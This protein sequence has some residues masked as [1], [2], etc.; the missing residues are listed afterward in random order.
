[1]KKILITIFLCSSVAL[2]GQRDTLSYTKAQVDSAIRATFVQI[3]GL[4]DVENAPNGN[5]YLTG[6]KTSTGELAKI[7]LKNLPIQDL[8]QAAL[9]QRVLLTAPNGVYPSYQSFYLAFLDSIRALWVQIGRDTTTPP[10]SGPD[11]PTTPSNF[12]LSTTTGATG[13]FILTWYSADTVVVYESTN[14]STFSVAT[15]LLPNTNTWTRSNITAG[16]TRYYYLRA[17]DSS[18]YSI[19]T[20]TLSAT[21]INPGSGV[22]WYMSTAA[23]GNGSGTS[24]ANAKLYSTSWS[25][26]R[27]GDVI[28]FDGGASGL[29]YGAIH[30]SIS[31]TAAQPITLTRGVDAGHNGT[32]TF[33]TTGYRSGWFSTNY[34]IIQYLNFTTSGSGSSGLEVVEIDGN[35]NIFQYNTIT[36]PNC[37]AVRSDGNGAGIGNKILHNTF[38]TGII[39]SATETDGIWLGNNGGNLEIAYNTIMIRNV[40]AGPHKDVIQTYGWQQ[41]AAT[42]SMTTTVHHNFFYAGGP[43]MQGTTILEFGGIGGRWH[44]YDNIMSY[45]TTVSGRAFGSGLCS[46]APYQSQ[47]LYLHIYN[48]TIYTSGAG[49]FAFQFNYQDSLIFV[50]NIVRVPPTNDFHPVS[51]DQSSIDNYCHFDYNIYIGRGDPFDYETYNTSLVNCDITNARAVDWSDWQAK[52]FD[53]H[54]TFSTSDA[55]SGLVFEGSGFPYTGT[56]I[57]STTP[58]DYATAS[59]SSNIDAG[60]SNSIA[61]TD[62]NDVARPQGSAYDIGAFE[63]YSGGSPGLDSIPNQ[64]NFT[65]LTNVDISTQFISTDITPTGFT[66]APQIS[67]SGNSAEYQL[68]LA[69]NWLTAPATLPIGATFRVRMLSSASNSTAVTCTVTVASTI[70]AIWTITTKS[71]SGGGYSQATQD[72]IARVEADGGTVIDPAEVEAI[73]TT[74]GIN[75]D[76]VLVWVSPHLGVKKNGSNQISRLYDL[77]NGDN[78]F[79]MD[80]TA[81]QPIWYA[82]S[83]KF[84]GVNDYMVSNFGGTYVQPN[85]F[86]LAFNDYSGSAGSN[87]PWDGIPGGSQEAFREAISGRYNEMSIYAGS[88][89]PID[90]PTTTWD[91]TL[92]H[93]MTVV[94]NST[95]STWSENTLG[96]TGTPAPAN[97]GFGNAGAYPT[98]GVT[99]GGRYDWDPA[100][101]C[102]IAIK[103]FIVY[104]RTGIRTVLEGSIDG[105]WGIWP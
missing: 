94:Y 53:A 84:D 90:C 20:A 27:P 29:T 1:M 104:A 76:S 100:G 2:F 85:T 98:K 68:G 56:T 65:N 103:E 89:G 25:A 40:A 21:I 95:D 97:G 43:G 45:Y 35:Y 73:Y 92:M 50:N 7:L 105:R 80:T 4:A 28:Y 67:I 13:S 26:I 30:P 81:K 69:G 48:N 62:Y 18:V 31:G 33:S 74:S 87:A 96:G 24:W 23:A 3:Y 6:V 79:V 8:V 55:A 42:S 71:A 99:L 41:S 52:G 60:V 91:G 61:T 5:D 36:M 78:D 101:Y 86:T 75:F 83:I 64:F 102:P 19:P 12:Q 57:L 9:N 37:K 10:P 17:R 14:G 15:T 58:G 66:T 88:P 93:I 38:D 11:V 16:N 47:P 39:N 63:Y 54:S 51:L 46:E 77:G 44:V 72:Y 59:G 32:P 22:S 70:S 82:D 49:A 34:L